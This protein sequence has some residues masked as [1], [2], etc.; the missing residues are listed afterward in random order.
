MPNLAK[1]TATV[2]MATADGGPRPSNIYQG[3]PLDS[4]KTTSSDS[5]ASATIAAKAMGG[6]GAL[7]IPFLL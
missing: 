3:S 2:S 1:A 6:V 5:G 4:S 7:I